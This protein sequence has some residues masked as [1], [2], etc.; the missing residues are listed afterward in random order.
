MIHY[1]CDRCGKRMTQGGLRY[2]VKMEVYAA[3]DATDEDDPVDDRDHLSEI[4]DI[5]ESLDEGNFDSV[6]DDIYK[7]SQFD[8][9]PDC[10][11]KL[12]ANP[13]GRKTAPQLNFSTN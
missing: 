9:C 12:L 4:N 10:Q 1:T 6:G 3:I 7:L 13:L 2:I 11:C 8:I 5:I